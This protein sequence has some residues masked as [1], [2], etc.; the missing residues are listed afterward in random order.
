MGRLFWKIFLTILVVQILLT[1]VIGFVLWLERPTMADWQREHPHPEAGGPD[2]RRHFEGPGGFPQNWAEREPRPDEHS[3]R[4]DMP[5]PP[6][7]FGEKGVSGP[8][9][10]VHPDMHG[11]FPPPGGPRGFPWLPIVGSCIASLLCAVLMARYLSRPI[12]ALRR[13][14][15]AVAKGNFDVHPVAEIGRRRDELAELGHEFENTARQLQGLLGNQRRLLHDVSHEVRSPLARMQLAIDLA[16]QQP[17]K[18]AVSMERIERESARIDRLVGEL[19][20]LSRLEAGVCGTMEEILDLTALIG[21]VVDDARFEAEAS[22]RKVD[23]NAT[24]EILIKG[25]GELL[26]RAI[27]NVVRNAVR[28]TFEN[29]VVT[30]SLHD[31]GDVLRICV[32]DDGPGLP[33][34]ALDTIFEPFVR[35]REESTNDGYGLGLAITRQTIEAHGGRVRAINRPHGGLRMEMTLPAHPDLQQAVEA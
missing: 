9:Q 21:E 28:H 7:R 26:Q 14:F 24:G 8:I 33:D 13:A 6:G 3:A 19:L 12:M 35:Y 2:D 17:E 34:S 16:R 5:A 4:T 25:H 22:H 10:Q 30:V 15:A 23:F 31:E 27:E 20:T 29:T 11:P 1:N 32:D 18:T